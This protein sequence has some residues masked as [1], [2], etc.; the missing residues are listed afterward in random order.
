MHRVKIYISMDMEGISG[1]VD[2]KYTTKGE[3]LYPTGQRLATEDVNAAVRG[4]FDAGAQEV[5][6]ADM[7]ANSCNLL[8]EQLDPRATL[9]AGTPHQPRFPFLDASVKGMFLVGYHALAGTY[10]A[11]LEHTMTSESWHRYRVNG[12]DT[13]ELGIDAAIAGE[14]GVPVVMVSG[15]D[16][17]CAEAKAWLGPVETACVKQGVGRT[18]SLCLS[19][20]QGRR[21]VYEAAYRAVQRLAAGERFELFASPSPATVTITYKH[22]AHADAA[23]EFGARRLDGYTVERDYGRISEVYG[24][25]WAD[26]GIAQCVRGEKA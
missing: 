18:C 21:K 5:I 9:L 10:A 17:L 22:S 2:P 6:V 15:D 25:I 3:W 1:I 19:P 24:G 8:V 4:A 11:T 20:E 13:G 26:L 12:R 16:K 23:C 14:S 7:H